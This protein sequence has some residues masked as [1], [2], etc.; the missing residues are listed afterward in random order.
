MGHYPYVVLQDV[1][2][3]EFDAL[4]KDVRVLNAA[5]RDKLDYSVDVH[6]RFEA[7]VIKQGWL[8]Q[9]PLREIHIGSYDDLA[10]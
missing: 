7:A 2:Q 3:S 4:V 8:A 9:I 1:Q 10:I 5:D 6:D